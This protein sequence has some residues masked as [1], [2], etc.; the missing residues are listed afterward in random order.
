L[1]TGGTDDAGAPDEENFHA[2]YVN[3][4]RDWREREARR[5]NRMVDC[6]GGL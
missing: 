1:R 3:A 5:G 4:V 6:S 2:R